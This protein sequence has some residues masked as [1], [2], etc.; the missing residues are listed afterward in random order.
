VKI[1]PDHRPE[2]QIYF[3][4]NFRGRQRKA[5]SKMSAAQRGCV[6]ASSPGGVGFF[7]HDVQ[8]YLVGLP[9]PL[10]GERGLETGRG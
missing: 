1:I 7:H 5:G 6:A 2:V 4:E 3:S 9:H 10:H 8:D